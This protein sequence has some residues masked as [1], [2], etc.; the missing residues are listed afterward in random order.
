[1]KH[2]AEY[3]GPD[4]MVAAHRDVLLNPNVDIAL[5]RGVL[6]ARDR[7]LMLCDVEQTREGAKGPVRARLWRS[8]LP[9]DEVDQQIASAWPR[10]GI[11][12]TAIKPFYSDTEVAPGKSIGPHT[13]NR[14]PMLG[15]PPVV[16]RLSYG[17][18][19][20]SL[21][22]AESALFGAEKIPHSHA[23]LTSPTDY[24]HGIHRYRVE[25]FPYKDETPAQA[26]VH[27][28]RT[29]VRPTAGDLVIFA[30]QTVHA[31]YASANRTAWLGA[32]KVIEQLSSNGGST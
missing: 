12:G 30:D 5:V 17:G 22:M 4:E 28:L 1:M 26:G 11:Q 18:T 10:I 24:V 13:D 23:P 20:Y 8:A 7:M 14:E 31:V 29:V 3:S 25:K 2:V 32:H 21:T 9:Q 16:K 15:P 6:S 19:S 27:D